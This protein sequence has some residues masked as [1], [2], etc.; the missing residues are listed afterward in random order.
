MRFAFFTPHK[1]FKTFIFLNAE[2]L[3]KLSLSISLTT[4]DT[5]ENRKHQQ[6][7]PTI[8]FGK[9]RFRYI[10]ILPFSL[11]WPPIWRIQ[12]TVH[13]WLQN[14]QTNLELGRAQKPKPFAQRECQF[15]HTY[16]NM[17]LW[18]TRLKHVSKRNNESAVLH[19]TLS[20]NWSR[21][22]HIL[23]IRP[24]GSLVPNHRRH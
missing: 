20:G 22:P 18:A 5:V 3:T 14:V 11:P 1:V 23:S 24:C 16:F 10:Y 8:L 9:L 2:K 12:S 4:F 7:H 6:T 13:H 17:F 19:F 15:T 21:A